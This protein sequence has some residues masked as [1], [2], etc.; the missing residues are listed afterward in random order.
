MCVC[1]YHESDSEYY[2]ESEQ[3]DSED[4][5]EEVQDSKM[6]TNKDK[7]VDRAEENK[8]QNNARKVENK[9]NPL[10]KT[11]VKPLKFSEKEDAA[12]TMETE[13]N[14]AVEDNSQVKRSS[15]RTRLIKRPS[16]ESIWSVVS[17]RK[18]KRQ[19]ARA[20]WMDKSGNK[21]RMDESECKV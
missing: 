15:R 8:T 5:N 10:S 12:E 2:E 19:S 6:K 1:S 11:Q 20:K 7:Q 9:E 16:D 18:Q 3:S 14:T 17:T 4:L 13:A 21:R